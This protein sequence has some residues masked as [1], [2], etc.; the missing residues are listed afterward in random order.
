MKSFYSRLNIILVIFFILGVIFSAYVL[1]NLPKELQL[2]S[3]RIDFSVIE[4]LKPLFIQTNVIIGITLFLGIAGLIFSLYLINSFKTSE[5]IVYVEK[6]ESQRRNEEKQEKESEEKTLQTKL[7]GI[8]AKIK[9]EKDHKKRC[10][11]FLSAVCNTLEASQGILYLTKKEK[12]KRLIEL[13]A[14][15]AYSL[16]DS[17]KLSYEFGEG[18]AG[19]AAKEGKKVNIKDVPEGYITVISGLGN[20]TPDHLFIFPLVESEETVALIE[21]ASF[22]PIWPSDEM[23]VEKALAL[24]ELEIIKTPAKKSNESSQVNKKESN[25]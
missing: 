16:P 12:N 6:S 24:S 4:K 14:A 23:L 1:F 10:D 7:D 8:R 3:S 25:Q 15:Y 17:E 11:K 9:S 5:K 18:L 22:R 21:I 13:Y 19:Q 20:A 2:A